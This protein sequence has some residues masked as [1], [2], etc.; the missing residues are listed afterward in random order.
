VPDG[1]AVRTTREVEVGVD[2]DHAAWL[3]D[4]L[5]AEKE[6]RGLSLAQAAK[7]IA[8]ESGATLTKQSFQLW[9][10]LETVPKL[11]QFDA[12]A[13]AFGFRLVVDLVPRGSPEPSAEILELAQG[14]AAL[15]EHDRRV[16][17]TVIN[18]LKRHVK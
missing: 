11:S 13:R 15:E 8:R 1:C 12:W 6:R 5:V 7:A 10:S 16:V 3:R 14:I 2:V 9:V 18:G 17:E 4:R